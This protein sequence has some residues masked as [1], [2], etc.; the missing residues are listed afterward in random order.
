MDD[1]DKLKKIDP[2]C[3]DVVRSATREQKEQIKKEKKEYALKKLEEQ[4]EKHCNNNASTSSRNDANVLETIMRLDPDAN[5]S[6]MTE[7]QELDYV[8]G[9]ELAEQASRDT[10]NCC[11]MLKKVYEDVKKM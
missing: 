2:I 8:K 9:L 4:I 7:K 3:K 5:I 10:K 6:V 1:F 11:Q